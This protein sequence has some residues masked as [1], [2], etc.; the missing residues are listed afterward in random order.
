MCV[1]YNDDFFC[2]TCLPSLQKLFWPATA[3]QDP[4]VLYL[5]EALPRMGR[6]AVRAMPEGWH[7]HRRVQ[8]ACAALRTAGGA[9]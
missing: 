9:R 3:R 8:A 6:R 7:H 2:F 1:H 5:A 4:T